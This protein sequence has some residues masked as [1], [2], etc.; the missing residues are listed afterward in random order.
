MNFDSVSEFSWELDYYSPNLR[1]VTF[2][3]FGRAFS[4]EAGN[5]SNLGV[6]LDILH[7]VKK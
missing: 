2:F 6:R 5:E 4:R 1:S 7:H 3:D